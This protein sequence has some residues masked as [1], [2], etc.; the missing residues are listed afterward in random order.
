MLYVIIAW[1]N[2]I[3]YDEPNLDI[4]TFNVQCGLIFTK[5]V[6]RIKINVF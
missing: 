2:I 1:K 3:E 4:Y 5:F 6:D